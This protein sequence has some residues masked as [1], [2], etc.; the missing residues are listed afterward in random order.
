[1]CPHGDNCHYA[2]NKLEQLY[3]PE[4]YK[5]KFCLHHPHNI[6]KC[7]YG[8]HCSFAHN[9]SEIMVELL[10]NMKQDEYFYLNKY[11]TVFCPYIYEHDRTQCIYAHNPQD[12]RRDLSKI[13][14]SPNQ[15][16]YWM[17]GQ[18][19]CYEEGGCPNQME[20]LNCHGWK[21]LEYHPL[22]YKTKPCNNL[23]K[24][25]KKE[26][27]FY[28]SNA[29]RRQPRT[30]SQLT[31]SLLQNSPTRN[32]VPQGM[33]NP[34][35]SQ[36]FNDEMGRPHSFPFT[37]FRLGSDPESNRKS[38]RQAGSSQGTTTTHASSVNFAEDDMTP[39]MS[40]Q[41][42]TQ[43]NEF[44]PGFQSPIKASSASPEKSRF[45]LGKN[46]FSPPNDVWSAFQP[47]QEDQLEDFFASGS[48]SLKV[49]KPS[50]NEKEDSIGSQEGVKKEKNEEIKVVQMSNDE[51]KE[52]FISNLDKKGLSHAKA[53]LI[54]PMIDIQALKSF[55]KKDFHLFPHISTQDKEKIVKVIEDILE[56]EALLCDVNILNEKEYPFSPDS[57][58]GDFFKCIG[59]WERN[60]DLKGI[61]E[62]TK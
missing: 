39:G 60:Q 59:S 57:D 11:K 44:Y 48:N 28:H 62:T 8:G 15:C 41:P 42:R 43:I 35:P 61:S 37:P 38:M 16:P 23:K 27:P 18:I 24:C 55:S 40:H 4:R 47:D 34:G 9:E 29:D 1:M 56:V 5:R 45:D 10:H 22:N 14:Y 50:T 51:F 32:F 25:N 31:R 6:H 49:P 58:E 33:F 54:N 30:T 17:Q 20:C 12:L 26:C 3:H 46:L 52:A 7:D 53:Y 36:Q 21:E 13:K 19:F 2:H